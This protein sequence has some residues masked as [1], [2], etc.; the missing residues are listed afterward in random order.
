MESKESASAHLQGNRDLGLLRETMSERVLPFDVPDSQW[1]RR[2][3]QTFGPQK[4]RN[5]VQ[6][7]VSP[8]SNK[9][10]KFIQKSN[11]EDS[12]AD[13]EHSDTDYEEY[14]VSCHESQSSAHVIVAKDRRL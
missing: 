2:G 12:A 9:R 14:N 6:D 4:W 7:N 1:E 8:C 5:Q 13:D 11:Q 10:F 3:M